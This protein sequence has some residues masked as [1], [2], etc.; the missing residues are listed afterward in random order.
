MNDSDSHIVKARESL[1]FA[2]YALAGEYTE[3]AG[4]SAY[5]A[6]YHAALAFIVAR[7]GKLPKTHSGA[8]SE[9]AR[10]AREEPGISRDQVSLLGWSYE[11]KNVAD[12][13]HKT[14]VS[15][16]EAERAIDEASRLVETI[17]T[18]I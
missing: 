11:L 17:A 4:R 14:T 15:P 18:L 7:T 8:R 10:L 6:A 9:F 1:T 12:Y 2:R 3:E 16:A 13:Q 5:M